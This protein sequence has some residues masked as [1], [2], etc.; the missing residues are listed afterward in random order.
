MFWEY[1]LYRGQGIGHK[2]LKNYTISK[3]VES[4]CKLYKNVNNN[5]QKPVHN[6]KS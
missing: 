1:K 3:A 4:D 5:L 2:K 6:I